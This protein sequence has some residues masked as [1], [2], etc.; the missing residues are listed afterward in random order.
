LKPLTLRVSCVDVADAAAPEE[1][2]PPRRR[3]APRIS[4]D[5]PR[6][7]IVLDLGERYQHLARTPSSHRAGADAARLAT[8]RLVGKWA[9]C[10]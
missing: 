4:P 5:A 8:A 10:G 7:T 6:E 3:G 2:L 9:E 1:H